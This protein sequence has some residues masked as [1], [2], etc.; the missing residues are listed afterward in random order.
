MFRDHRPILLLV[1]AALVS[2]SDNGGP[3]SVA[4]ST[5]D[6]HPTQA[7]IVEHGTGVL[8]FDGILSLACL[9]EDVHEVLN[10]PYTFQ[11]VTTPSGNTIYREPFDHKL[12]TGTMTGLSTGTVWQRTTTVSPFVSRNTAGGGG[13]THFTSMAK[14]VSETGPDI[15]GTQ[16]F[17]ISFDAS[18]RVTAEHSSFSCWTK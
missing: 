9:D 2:C 18:G 7:D 8:V 16:V 5:G 4:D 13:M 6:L 15:H 3:L 11:R 12:V 1:F 14:W 10:A 17:H